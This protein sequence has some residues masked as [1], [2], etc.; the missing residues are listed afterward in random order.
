LIIGIILVVATFN[1][2]ATLIVLIMERT[3]MIDVLKALGARDHTVKRIFINNGLLILGKGLLYGNT[4]ALLIAVLQ[5]YFEII[6]L[7]PE[8]YYME[9]VPIR[10]VWEYIFGVNLLTVL[11]V[12]IFLLIPVEVISRIKPVSA[13]KFS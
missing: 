1:M 11:T 2:I 8:N 12:G 9:A 4:I 3:S 5:Y 10:F 13:I 6:P 7:N